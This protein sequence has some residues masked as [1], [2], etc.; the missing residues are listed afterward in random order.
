MP[1]PENILK[2]LEEYYTLGQKIEEMMEQELEIIRELVR[3]LKKEY[4]K[5]VEDERVVKFLARELWTILVK[6]WDLDAKTLK[7][8]LLNKIDEYDEECFELAY[9]LTKE[10]ALK[11]VTDEVIGV[12]LRV[13]ERLKDRIKQY[14]ELAEKRIRLAKY[15]RDIFGLE[16]GDI[17]KL[18]NLVRLVYKCVKYALEE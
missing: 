17:L 12:A 6:P 14:N 16:E 4:R 18:D 13:R 15:R 3:E 10:D 9:D 11:Y 2:K 1:N 8:K 5:I 7:E